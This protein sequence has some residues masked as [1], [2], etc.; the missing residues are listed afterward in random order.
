MVLFYQIHVDY[1]L[2]WMAYMV[3]IIFDTKLYL[4]H[5][6]ARSQ[7]WDNN[8]M[9]KL[10]LCE[11]TWYYNIMAMIL[12][13]CYHLYEVQTTIIHFNRFSKY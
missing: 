8:I 6:P 1:A 5:E 13:Q 11:Q 10:I 7:Y 3:G 12:Y 2:F 4:G 9:L